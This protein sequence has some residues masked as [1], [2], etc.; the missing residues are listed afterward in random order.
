ME[1]TP[2]A[3]HLID[4]EWESANDAGYEVVSPNDGA[5]V[6]RGPMGGARECEAAIQAA[7]KAFRQG[8]WASSP[9]L[10]AQVML[11]QADNIERE[12]AGLADLL[13]RE[14][15]KLIGVARAEVAASASEVRYY[16]G[17]ARAIAGRTFEIEPGVHSNLYREPAGVVGI[18][19]PW[20]APGIL[21]VR[22]LAPALA[23]G[24][25][26]VLKPAAQSSLFHTALMRCFSD[27]PD[28]PAGVLNSFCEAGSDGAEHLVRSPG[29]DVVSFTGS[30]AVG[31][32]I[33]EAAAGTLKRLNLE[34]GGKAPGIVFEDCDP[35]RI[36]PLLAASGMILSGQQCTAMNRVLVH[37]SRFEAVRDA[38]AGAL[39]A[40]K[41]GPSLEDGVA[42]GPVIDPR[43]RDRIRALV[44][45]HARDA[46]LVG[47]VPEDTPAGGAFI[48]PSLLGVTA[49]ESPVVQEEFFGPVMNIEPFS[50]EEEAVERANGTRYGLSASVWTNDLDRANRV[51]RALRAGT[52][53]LNDHNKLFPEAETGGFRDS[54]YGRLHGMD[55]L[56]EFLSTK[57]VYHRHGCV[58]AA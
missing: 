15:G 11:R 47:T 4:G 54:G 50:S 21:L 44:A 49:M 8:A 16:A 20:N 14:T 5:L 7:S 13:A 29:V 51:A 42:V 9:R 38:L 22:S 3:A 46:V 30:S 39:S 1:R 33:M 19:T 6:G 32:R 56:A 31:K 12:A 17:L 35:D 2:M 18:I 26:V 37:E 52:V 25:T 34:L 57:H 24:C 23:A 53:W 28:L 41:V 40:L 55:G 43:S 48:R 10:R 45:A 36:A 27:V 58:G